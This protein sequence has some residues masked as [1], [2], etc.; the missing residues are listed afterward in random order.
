FELLQNPLVLLDSDAPVTAPDAENAG[1]DRTASSAIGIDALHNAGDAILD[2]RGRLDA[3]L[4]GLLGVAPE[5]AQAIIARLQAGENR[6]QL[7]PA[8]RDLPPLPK[9]NVLACLA[10]RSPASVTDVLELLEVQAAVACDAVCRAIGQSRGRAELEQVPEE[11][12][13]RALASLEE[14]QIASV[15]ETLVACGRFVEPLGT[16]IRRVLSGGKAPL[17][18]KLA[19]WI[20]AYGRAA[21]SELARRRENV[22]AACNEIRS[23][24]QDRLA[25]TQLTRA[26]RQWSEV[27]HPLWLLGVP[28]G[29][30]DALPL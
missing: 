28:M 30:E 1:A 15:V 10:A 19:A 21:A 12:V 3:E 26:L 27:E 20:R 29:S 13:A 5:L 25:V 17:V 4:S 8:I 14:R 16:L 9:S 23:N 24:P 2:L 18:A 11:V 6:N 7:D 22:R